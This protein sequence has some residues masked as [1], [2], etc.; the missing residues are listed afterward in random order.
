MRQKTTKLYK[1]KSKVEKILKGK[2]NAKLYSVNPLVPIGLENIT[3][4]LRG[5]KYGKKRIW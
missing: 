2:K 5:E 3:I 1:S 4:K